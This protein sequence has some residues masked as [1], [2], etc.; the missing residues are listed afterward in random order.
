MVVTDEEGSGYSVA[1]GRDKNSPISLKHWSTFLRHP[2]RAW[3]RDQ[4]ISS[5]PS[6][7]ACWLRF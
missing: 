3:A 2:G 7:D 4:E 1:P 6:S 5:S